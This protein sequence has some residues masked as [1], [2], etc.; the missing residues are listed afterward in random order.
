KHYRAA[1]KAFSRWA[2]KSGRLASDPLIG[3]T[4]YNAKADVPH[5]RRAI[6]VDELRRLIEAARTGPRW[7]KMSGLARAICYRT[8]VATG[9][10]YAELQSVAPESF[11]WKADPPTVTVA[12]G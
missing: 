9:L 3:V 12:A 5:D 11:D 2:W 6:G 8:T 10:R 4:G 7:R 1:A